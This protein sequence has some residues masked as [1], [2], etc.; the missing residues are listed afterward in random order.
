[1]LVEQP[2]GGI[3]ELIKTKGKSHIVL[4]GDVPVEGEACPV[5]IAIKIAV[6]LL[7]Q[8]IF[9]AGGRIDGISFTGRG[10]VDRQ[11]ISAAEIAADGDVVLFIGEVN[12]TIFLAGAGR[13]VNCP[14][15]AFRFVLFDSNRLPGGRFNEWIWFANQVAS[16]RFSKHKFRYA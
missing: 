6:A 14:A 12:G 15:E 1:V 16:T 9:A 2:I 10:G 11:L 13:S 7:A 3:P 8:K 5:A 4:G